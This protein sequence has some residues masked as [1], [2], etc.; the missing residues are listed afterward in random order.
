MPPT[1]IVQKREG[2]VHVR[3]ACSKQKQAETGSEVCWAG[4]VH[5]QVKADWV[6][7]GYGVVPCA[8]GLS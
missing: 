1:Q 6:D 8:Q 5:T 2:V 4:H 3:R 7:V